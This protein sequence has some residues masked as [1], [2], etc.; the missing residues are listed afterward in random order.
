MQVDLAARC[1]EAAERPLTLALFDLNGF[2]HYNDTYGHPA[3]DRMLRAVGGR[4]REVVEMA[5]GA[6]YRVGGDEFGVLLPGPAREREETVRRAAEALSEQGPGYRIDCSRGTASVPAEART[7][8]EA[9]E[10]ADVRMY[11]QKESRRPGR[12]GPAAIEEAEARIRLDG[13][14]SGKAVEQGH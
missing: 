6:A 7:P 10:L 3:G 14:G 1:A 2:K 9:M 11:A 13:P 5:G 4:L 12:A 8:I